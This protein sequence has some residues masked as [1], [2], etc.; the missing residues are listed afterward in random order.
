MSVTASYSPAITLVV[1]VAR[2]I[3]RENSAAV[4]IVLV[5]VDAVALV[6]LVATEETDV[7]EG[8]GIALIATQASGLAPALA[9][10]SALVDDAVLGVCTRWGGGDGQGT[11]H[12]G[13][14]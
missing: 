11:E 12:Q 3:A 1:L 10:G 4:A 8:A 13:D 5:S 14:N 2:P 6:V 9:V 7:Q